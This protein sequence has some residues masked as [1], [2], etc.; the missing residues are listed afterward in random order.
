MKFLWVL[1]CISFFPLKGL[2]ATPDEAGRKLFYFKEATLSVYEVDLPKRRLLASTSGGDASL[3]P[4]R[5]PR[6]GR[7][8]FFGN[9][10][11]VQADAGFSP[12]LKK[13]HPQGFWNRISENLW[14]VETGDVVESLE[15][16]E[17]LARESGVQ[18]ARPVIYKRINLDGDL[19]PRP[20]DPYFHSQWNLENR[21]SNGTIKG[22]ELNL[23]PAWF[24]T[25]GAGTTIAIVDSGVELTHPE[26]VH[27]QLPD[28]HFNFVKGVPD[29]NPMSFSYE[30]SHGTAVAGL[31]LA[32]S[33]NG[34][35]MSG[36]A[37][38]SRLASWVL[39]FTNDIKASEENLMKMYQ[40][41]MDNIQVQNHSWGN[42]GGGQGGF[43]FLENIGISN[44]VTLGRGGL[45]VVMVRSAGNGRKT[46]E[47]ANDDSYTS[48]PRA[49]GVASVRSDGR[50]TRDSNPGACILVAAPSSEL[51]RD[52][53]E[54]DLDFETLFTTD[55]QGLFGYN[56]FHYFEDETLSDYCFDTTAFKGTS[57]A[58][59]QISGIAAL[60]LSVNPR[61]SYRDVQQILIHSAVHFYSQPDMR[62]NAA[63]FH[64]SHNDGFG[65]PDAGK[66][67][68]LAVSWP[69]RPSLESVVVRQTLNQT[70]PDDGFRF[71][72][73]NSTGLVA[74]VGSTPGAGMLGL[75]FSGPVGIKDFEQ[76]MKPTKGFFHG[77]AALIQRGGIAFEDKILNAAQ[78]GAGFV[79][80]WN[81]LDT[82][83]LIM[84]STDFVPIPAVFISEEAGRAVLRAAEVSSVS[85]NP[86]FQSFRSK[87]TV[88][89]SLLCEQVGLKVTTDHARRGDLLILLTSPSG[90]RSVLQRPNLDANPGPV[91]WTYFTTHSFYESSVGDWGVE[92]FD[93]HPGRTGKIQSLELKVLGVPIV[94][95][96]KDGLDDVWENMVFGSLKFSAR[97]D[98]DGDGASNAREQMQGTNPAL[99]SQKP[100]LSIS[101]FN[102]QY[103]RVS[104]PFSGIIIPVLLRG[105]NPDTI[106]NSTLTRVS[107]WEFESFVPHQDSAMEFFRILFL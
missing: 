72:F 5:D 61:L 105:E 98:I 22:L 32:Q 23:R 101:R 80:V 93:T 35:G 44:A 12:A 48:D 74:N 57:G 47:N 76:G 59:P 67:V 49:I 6:S 3:V 30:L 102:K 97:D 73:I 53:F 63:G 8:I 85:F 106:A 40:Y 94:D 42:P 50:T 66:A 107:A 43:E 54:M 78:S 96:D 62:T 15:L 27:R 69:P 86:A 79:F 103:L 19:A 17:S 75:D 51:V 46:F 81:R 95:A 21:S 41:H 26:F 87:I 82:N 90:T 38:E 70:I 13:L 28:F 52:G 99:V 2:A 10:V 77:E 64:V 88:T 33:G 36:V 7:M 55:R 24:K 104:F 92:I 4:A 1:L 89:N 58:A 16:A 71:D 60:I 84:G 11:L 14:T 91:D 25:R 65:V 56:T 45:G 34:L 37:P 83:R 29:G 68:E 20:G 31:A 18:L 9:K 100:R 39:F